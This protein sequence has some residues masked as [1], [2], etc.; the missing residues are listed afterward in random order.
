MKQT[1]YPPGWDEAR[2][3]K[4]LRHYEK[5]TEDEAVAEDEAAYGKSD[6]A[7]MVVPK[8]L[9]PAITKLIARDAVG[10]R[11]TA[12]RSTKPRKLNRSQGDAGRK[13]ARLRSGPGK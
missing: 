6:Q 5:Q 9:V 13:P 11:R 7:V 12:H 1:H 10:K 8:Q 4:L 3:R 2:V